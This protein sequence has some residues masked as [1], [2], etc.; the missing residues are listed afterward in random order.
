M[1]C[2]TSSW[3]SKLHPLPGLEPKDVPK[4]GL[5]FKTSSTTRAVAQRCAQSWPCGKKIVPSMLALL[6][7]GRGAC[8]NQSLVGSMS[9]GNR[10][11]PS[12]LAFFVAGRGACLNQSLVGSMSCGK[13]VMPSMLAFLVAERGACLNQSLVGS[14]QMSL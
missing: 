10:V 1:A 2:H 3:L 12:M 7:A 6:V 13:R 8:L 9:C 14:M 4:V 11:M 5:A